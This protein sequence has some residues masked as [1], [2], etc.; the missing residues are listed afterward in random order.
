MKLLIVESP[1]KVAKLKGFLGQGWDVLASVGHVRDLP[2]KE[3]GV[4]A[5]NFRPAYIPTDR[6]RSVLAKLDKAVK[7]AAEVYLATDPDRE[8]EAIA[9]HIKDALKLT[10]ERRVT[11][12]EITEKAVKAAVANPR[13]LDMNLVAAQEAR[14]VLDRLVGYLVPRPLGNLLGGKRP[15]GRV[16]TPALR[17][18][19]ERERDIRDHRVTTHYGVELV[20]DALPN[21]SQGWKATW[22]IKEWLPQGQEHVL[23]KHLATEIAAVRR[24]VVLSCRD[25]QASSAPPAPFTTSTL[26]QAASNALKLS[27]KQTMGAAQKLYEGGH[28]TYMRTDSPNLSDEAV[29]E[30]QEYCR[31]QG[32]PVVI[33]PR[34]WKGKSGAQ[35]AHEAIRPTHIE[36]EEAGETDIERALYDLIRR[37]TLASQLEDALF[38]VREVV[39]QGEAVNGK[40]PVFEAKGR[41]LLKPGWKVVM[42]TDQADESEEE[43]ENPV[44]PLKDGGQLAVKEGLVL[45]KKTK[46]RP[47]YTE[48]ALVKALENSG[49]GRPSTYAA[50]LAKIVDHGYVRLEKRALVPTPEG[51]AVITALVGKFAFLEFAFTQ[52]MEGD[53]DAVAEGQARYLDTIRKFY[54]SFEKELQAFQSALP[55]Y[56]CPDC[57][58]P[59]IHRVKTGPKG[60]DFWGCSGYPDCT[61]NFFPDGDK[62]G[63]RKERQGKPSLSE[64]KC[65]DCGKPLVHRVK[66]GFGGY[67]FWGCSGFPTCKASFDDGNGK[68][69]G[70]RS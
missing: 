13:L 62:P 29:A 67:N 64:H 57:G 68:P 55:H 1:G 53:L 66:E 16:Q 38:A 27:P 36:V 21:I 19:V 61:A 23:D 7:G 4:A 3:I 24:V 22:R 33:K 46:P 10:N 47:R 63:R 60:Y 14:R 35:E 69:K 15:A 18:I 30:I 20:F 17:L 28:I 52:S 43:P 25:S 41:T 44:P 48:A 70:A 39:L 34:S 40:T 42:A 49:I 12:T 59:L 6:G 54:A 8:G 37:R 51:E 31:G 56:L 11:Y 5:P 2:E 9:W 50:I 26:Q 65:P 58:N 32:W 45:T